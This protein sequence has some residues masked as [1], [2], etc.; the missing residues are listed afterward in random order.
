MSDTPL[1]MLAAQI[2]HHHWQSNAKGTG[3]T[4]GVTDR[5]YKDRII[6]PVIF[7]R[8]EAALVHRRSSRRRFI[9][10]SFLF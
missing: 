9:E 7:D 4:P 10:A 6:R 2:N 1:D 3:N 8:C 5:A